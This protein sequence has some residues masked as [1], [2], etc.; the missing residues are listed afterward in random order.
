MPFNQGER[1]AHNAVADSLKTYLYKQAMQSQSLRAFSVDDLS[2]NELSIER[3]KVSSEC[4]LIRIRSKN[5]CLQVALEDLLGDRAKSYLQAQVQEPN[6]VTFE[7]PLRIFINLIEDNPS[8]CDQICEQSRAYIIKHGFEEEC[9]D[10]TIVDGYRDNVHRATYHLKLIFSFNTTNDDRASLNLSHSRKAKNEA[11][12]NED[13]LRF[14]YGI[15]GAA[16]AGLGVK[17]SAETLEQAAA[18]SHPS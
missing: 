1:T 15:F 9:S 11:K 14:R 5:D 4:L 8:F 17:A 7:L 6:T 18:A 3:K 10:G 2:D 13:A 12:R 16:L